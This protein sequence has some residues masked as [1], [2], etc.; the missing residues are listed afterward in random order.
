MRYFDIKNAVSHDALYFLADME[1]EGSLK[2]FLQCFFPEYINYK[3]EIM[4]FKILLDI[5]KV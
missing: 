2:E 3:D 4:Y 5:N 1:E